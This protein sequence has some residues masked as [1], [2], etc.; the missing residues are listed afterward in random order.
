MRVPIAWTTP[1][2]AVLLVA[3][4]EDDEAR[5]LRVLE[6]DAPV[7]QKAKACQRLAVIGTKAA[8]PVL[9]RLLESPELA[10]YARFGLEPIPDPSVDDVLRAAL[11]KLKGRLQVGVIT[12]IGVRKDAKALD[13]LSKL[14]NT[15][16]LPADYF[17]NIR[18][19]LNAS[20]RL[21]L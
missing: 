3:G 17:V 10:H 20:I 9:A 13:A 8:V 12:S 19:M 16:G 6:S 18:T 2:V 14:M 21:P 4:R 7:F 11:P 5:L 15:N 1:L